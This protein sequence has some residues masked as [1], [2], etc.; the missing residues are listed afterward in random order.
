MEN[1]ELLAKLESLS[2]DEMT[3][4][5][6]ELIGQSK[7]TKIMYNNAVKILKDKYPISEPMEIDNYITA[8]FIS[9]TYN[10]SVNRVKMLFGCR[11]KSFINGIRNYWVNKNDYSFFFEDDRFRKL[12]NDIFNKPSELKYFVDLTEMFNRYSKVGNGFGEKSINNIKTSFYNI[13]RFFILLLIENGY[14]KN[15]SVQKRINNQDKEEQFYAL[16]FNVAGIEYHFHQPIEQNR[17]KETIE[18]TGLKADN[19]I[20]EEYS[21][22]EIVEDFDDKEMEKYFFFLKYFKYRYF[23]EDIK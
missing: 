17:L 7:V 3:E 5:L 16:T 20:V 19:D 6:S 12:S 13:K 1:K 23:N 10:M 15:Y 14:L 22:Y 21:H 11:K 4:L 8:S 9:Q 2:R 18:K